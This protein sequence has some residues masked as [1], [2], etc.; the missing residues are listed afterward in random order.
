MKL[1]KATV[2]FVIFLLSLSL[3]VK[4]LLADSL[5]IGFC[6]SPPTQGSPVDHYNIYESVDSSE[7]VEVAT[8]TDTCSSIEGLRGHTYKVRVAAVDSIGN[9]GPLSPESPSYTVLTLTRVTLEDLDSGSPKYSNE[10]SVRVKIEEYKGGITEMRLAQDAL[11]SINST[12]WQELTPELSYMLTSGDGLREIYTQL[13]D[14]LGYT[15]QVVCESIF[16]DT[17]PPQAKVSG[18]PDYINTL[19]FQ[20]PYTYSDP[21]PSSGVTQ[22]ELFY[23]KNGEGWVSYGTESPDG[24][25]S[26]HSGREGTYFFVVVAEDSAG[27][28]ENQIFEA[29]D[30]VVVDTTAPVLESLIMG[31]ISSGSPRFTNSDSLALSLFYTGSPSQMRLAEDPSFSVNSTGWIDIAESYLYILTPGAEGWRSVFAQVRD[32]A[33]NRSSILSKSIFLDKAP[34]QAEVS[35]LPDYINQVNFQ[36]PYTYSDPAPSSGVAQV[37]LYYR[38][39]GGEWHLY[40]SASPGNPIIFNA[41]GDTLYLFEMIAE[42]S[43]GNWE[44]RSFLAE[45]SVVVKTDRLSCSISLS[46]RPPSSSRYTNGDTVVVALGYG[47]YPN[48]VRLA[49]DPSF[50]MN[51]TGWIPLQDTL[52][53]VL[54]PSLGDGWRRVY[55]QVKD[56]ADNLSPVA[57]D[58]IFLDRVN[59]TSWVTEVPDSSNASFFEIHFA[60]TDSQPSSGIYQIQLFYKYKWKEVD[61]ILSGEAASGSTFYFSADSGDGYYWFQTIAQ[62]SA[63]NVEAFTDAPE[64]STLVDTKGPV[65]TI[66]SPSPGETLSCGAQTQILWSATDENDILTLHIFYKFQEETEWDSIAVVEGSD[67]TYLWQVPNIVSDSCQLRVVAYDFLHNSGQGQT[68]GFFSIVDRTPPQVQVLVPN[69][70][71]RWRVGERDTIKFKAEDNIGIESLSVF[72]SYDGGR[73]YGDTIARGVVAD[74]LFVW[75]ITDSLTSDS[76]IVRILAYDRSGNVGMDESDSSFIILPPEGVDN[77]GLTANLPKEFGLAQNYPN[78]FNPT[79]VIR[80]SLPGDRYQPSAI[81]G[82]RAG[83]TSTIHVSLKVYN[84]LGGLVRT[85]VDEEQKPGYY[86]VLWDGRDSWG[87]PVASGVYICRL[88]VIGDRGKMIKSRKMVLIR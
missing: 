80:Y 50:N 73:T 68:K 65:V 55:A 6:W 69:G 51:S 72:L 83:A 56:V 24:S 1:K 52:M 57:N 87:K 49:E 78:P 36:I 39:K 70:G 41:T 34:P 58:S 10:E 44:E 64:G 48:S 47:G 30:S 19:S 8:A 12:D 22:V 53:F 5:S 4:S 7:Y 76:C 28:I 63:G 13:R 26:F 35:G 14:S 67:S 40:G 75:E 45:D 85:L 17:A 43:A 25:F 81:G 82:S 77:Q 88:Q 46:N 20:I 11:F 2:P 21:Y 79:T 61:W 71:E 60:A 84:V 18:L 3:G 37:K 33:G 66:Y 15:S 9:V 74:S 27:N 29:E 62:D 42:D 54:S 32:P 38:K 59:P 23:K 31:D 86:R 16:L